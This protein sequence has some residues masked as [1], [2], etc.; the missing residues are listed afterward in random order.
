MSDDEKA[1]FEV[2]CPKCKRKVKVVA[3]GAATTMKVRC[4]CGETIELVKGLGA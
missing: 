2:D 4:A 1:S 3:K